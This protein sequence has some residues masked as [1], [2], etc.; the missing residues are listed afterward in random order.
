[1]TAREAECMSDIHVTST[2]MALREAGAVGPKMFQTILAAFGSPENVYGA[3][4]DDLVELPQVS[5]E[6]AARILSSQQAVPMMAE[7]LE[8]L[9]EEE[10]YV[11]TYLD[12]GYPFK[13][14]SLD[15][16]PPVLYYRGRL[17]SPT[18]KSISIVGTTDATS[19]GIAAT[20]DISAKISGMGCSIVS[21]L[22]RG[23]D[24]AAH[25]GALKND[26]VT[27]AV[28]GS[29][30]Y[31]IYPEENSSLAEQLCDKGAL[32][33]EYPPDATVNAGRLIARNRVVVGLS[34]TTIVAELS[35]EST[36]S[37]S[38]A[39][40]CDRQ[41]KLLFYLLQRNEKERGIDIPHNAIPFET[42]DD[43]ETILESS[44]GS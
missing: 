19:G 8:R 18:Q 3:A 31:N 24:A 21:G 23:I 33:T 22:A 2:V 17:P 25:I 36:G 34:D 38:A 10:I 15:D 35:P 6:R 9:S 30:L 4:I 27:H 28:I 29:G 26:G 41:G 37:F 44:V 7:R 13:L 5:H 20:V 14:R 32:M 1:M 11:S 12:D 40:A 42:L 43:I 39:E 16:P